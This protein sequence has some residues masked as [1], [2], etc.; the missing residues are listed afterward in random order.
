MNSFE[1]KPHVELGLDRH[2]WSHLGKNY[3][4]MENKTPKLAT[5]LIGSSY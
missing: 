1:V 3:K 5:L 2:H 4:T